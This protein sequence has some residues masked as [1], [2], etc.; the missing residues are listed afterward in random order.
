MTAYVYADLTTIYLETISYARTYKNEVTYI[1]N[2]SERFTQ[3]SYNE[4]DELYTSTSFKITND[5]VE[6]SK[7]SDGFL[8]EHLLVLE[9][10]DEYGYKYLQVHQ[11]DDE[12]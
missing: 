4:T 1:N 10:T 12:G 8:S 5:E 9:I 11:A 2:E 6:T 3:V 7:L